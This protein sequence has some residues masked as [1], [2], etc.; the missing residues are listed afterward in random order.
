MFSAQIKDI[1]E[2]AE[3]VGAGSPPAWEAIRPLLDKA[4]QGCSLAPDE[5]VAVV[6]GTLSPSVAG[7]IKEMAARLRRPHDREILLLPPL[8]ISSVCENR[9][10]YCEFGGGGVRLSLDDFRIEI[11]ALLNQGFRSI[12]LVSGQDIELFGHRQEPDWGP[13]NQW[14]DIETGAAYF[15][16]A[17]G[18]LDRRGGGMLTSNIPPLDTK[19]MA[20]LREAGLDCFLVWQETFNPGQYAR[21]HPQ[22]GPKSDQSFRLDAFE[23]ARAGGI[24]HTAGAF[25]KGLYDWRKEEVVLYLLDAHLKTATGRGL[26][27]IGTPRLK[28]AAVRSPLVRGYQVSD[29][30]YELNVALDRILFNGIHWLQT[31]ESLETNLHLIERYGGG[32]ILTLLCSTAPGGY[33]A[34]PRGKAQFPVHRQDTASSVAAL[35]KLGF[36][37]HF[38]W[39]AETLEAFQRDAGGF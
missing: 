12:E 38:D 20:R 26:S 15:A 7:Q 22:R 1:S 4:A 16:Q 9:C 35:E 21:L 34:P 37:V 6:E 31:R 3:K 14:F 39:N 27:I 33:G 2:L 32:V 36:K 19:G 28:G 30:D 18:L 17:R 5:I 10:T 8:Y 24:P 11:E 23:R 25:L 13:G 29:E